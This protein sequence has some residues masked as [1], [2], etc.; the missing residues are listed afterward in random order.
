MAKVNSVKVEKKQI[1]ENIFRKKGL[2]TLLSEVKFSIDTTD[3]SINI[4]KKFISAIKK[5]FK[6]DYEMT[7]DKYNYFDK[8]NIHPLYQVKVEK[9]ED[10]DEK[11]RE[12]V[13]RLVKATSSLAK[14]KE[15][16]NVVKVTVKNGEEEYIGYSLVNGEIRKSFHRTGRAFRRNS[17]YGYLNLFDIPSLLAETI[18]VQSLIKFTENNRELM[19]YLVVE[20][21]RQHPN[22]YRFV[23]DSLGIEL[24][25]EY[26][27]SY[28]EAF[29]TQ[30]DTSFENTITK[31][32]TLRHVITDELLQ[33]V[34]KEFVNQTNYAQY[35]AKEEYNERSAYA[36]A[37]QTKKQ[38]KLSHQEKMKDNAFLER[39]GYVELDN[40][41]DLEKFEI[42]EENFKQLIK[43]VAIP[44]R[45]DYSFRIKKLGKLRAEGAFYPFYKTTIFDINHPDAYIHESFHQIDSIL[46]E[47]KGEDYYSETLAFRH[48][49]DAYTTLMAHAIQGLPK[50]HPFRMQWEGTTKYNKPYYLK[51]TEVFARTGE[52][53]ISQKGFEPNSLFKEAE[54]LQKEA[55]Y[56][57]EESFVKQVIAFFD[58]LFA[59]EQTLQ[60][61]PP[62][63]QA[64]FVEKK[65]RKTSE[66]VIQKVEKQEEVFLYSEQLKLF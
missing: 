44:N 60:Q 43:V 48:L 32:G 8:I 10:S 3:S 28:E 41:V 61:E 13:T 24:M 36:K 53:Y 30:D 42:V 12:Y 5:T 22:S 37:F 56:P 17:P 33:F 62:K 50:D 39:Y 45:K 4:L 18:A 51:P 2:P 55:V 59:K 65:P 64:S 23:A 29:D 20:E 35:K 7:S 26:G 52:I 38:I 16:P 21:N 6:K 25:D 31:V 46:G 14:A 34:V 27:F 15:E 63:K 19:K 57:F 58:N 9:L 1:V 11:F 54:E 49:L 66:K 47:E 40:D